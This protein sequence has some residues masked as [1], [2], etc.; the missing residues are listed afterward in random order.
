MKVDKLMKDRLVSIADSINHVAK[1]G[2]GHIP[3]KISC[4]MTNISLIE[5]EVKRLK[6]LRY[7]GK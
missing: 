2:E 6:Q 7:L 1:S 4:L 3:D 5:L